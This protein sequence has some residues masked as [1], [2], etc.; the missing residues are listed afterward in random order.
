[1]LWVLWG[2]VEKKKKKAGGGVEEM[3][4]GGFRDFFFPSL[5][6]DLVINFYFSTYLIYSLNF[7]FKI[8][9]SFSFFFFLKY[10]KKL[11]IK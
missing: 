8:C 7:F 4:T 9:F 11:E 6:K 10:S 1:M 2:E 3:D 5:C